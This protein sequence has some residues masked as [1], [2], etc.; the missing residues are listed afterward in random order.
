LNKRYR[1]QN[2]PSLSIFVVL[3]RI[4]VLK[5][6]K[7]TSDLAD[8]FPPVKTQMGPKIKKMASD[9]FSASLLTAK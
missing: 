5:G 9:Y 3:G 4:C 1:S 7:E 2:S 6:I 8:Y